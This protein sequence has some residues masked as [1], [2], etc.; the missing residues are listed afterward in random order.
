MCRLVSSGPL[1]QRI[2]SGLPRR[3]ITSSSTRVLYIGD[4]VTVDGVA[5]INSLKVFDSVYTMVRGK[6]FAAR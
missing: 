3:A 6:P 2:P 1:S 4:P 5:N